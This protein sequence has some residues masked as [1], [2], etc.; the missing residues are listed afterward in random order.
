MSLKEII[1]E[2]KLGTS[3]KKYKVIVEDKKTKKK[4]TIQFGAKGFEQYKDRSPLKKY[5]SKN[6][7]DIKR[8]KN[9]F[10]R[11]SGVKSKME[12]IKKET[13]KSDGKYNAKILS[14]KYLW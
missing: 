5:S 9:Y 14:H 2:W 13:L 8:R 10:S 1:I 12:A 3:N 11:H 6:H 7:L 4:R